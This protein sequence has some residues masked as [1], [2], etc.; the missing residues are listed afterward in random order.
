MVFLLGQ[1]SA[2]RSTAVYLVAPDRSVPFSFSCHCPFIDMLWGLGTIFNKIWFRV[3]CAHF[4]H[5]EA[6]S[7]GFR[8]PFVLRVSL[9]LFPSNRLNLYFPIDMPISILNHEKQS[10]SFV[11]NLIWS[12]LL[13]CTIWITSY[14][15]STPLHYYALIA[16]GLNQIEGGLFYPKGRVCR[17]SLPLT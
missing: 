6:I 5:V 3:I 15:S 9:Y 10:L 2:L 12:L 14:P 16:F 17:P 8:I 1:H 13:F 4:P 7:P 11:S